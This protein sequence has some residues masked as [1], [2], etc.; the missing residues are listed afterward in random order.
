MGIKAGET[1]L[2]EYM[3]R[4]SE[5]PLQKAKI[6]KNEQNITVA[7]V[8][9]KR[10]LYDRTGRASDWFEY[11]YDDEEPAAVVFDTAKVKTGGHR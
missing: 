7:T 8:M 5:Q 9:V 6:N 4:A 11:E 10:T 1:V 3:A 2:K